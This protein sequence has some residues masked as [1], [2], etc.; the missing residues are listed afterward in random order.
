MMKNCFRPVAYA[1][2]ETLLMRA[3]FG[4]AIYLAFGKL[5]TFSSA[6]VEVGIGHWMDLSVFHQSGWGI[7]GPFGACPKNMLHLLVGI[8]MVAFVWGRF[9]WLTLPVVAFIFV[10][11]ATLNTSQGSTQHHLQ[12]G[13]MVLVV[14]SLWYLGT[15]V[16]GRLRPSRA[17]ALRVVHRTAPFLAIQVLAAAYVVAGISKLKQSGLAWVTDSRF[18]PVALRKTADQHYFSVTDQVPEAVV[19]LSDR[20]P[21]LVRELFLEHPW[22]AGI[23]VGPGLFL[24]LLAFLA[25]AGRSAALV[26][27]LLLMGFHYMVSEVMNLHFELNN[28]LL[29]IFLVNVPF[30]IVVAWRRLA[31]CIGRA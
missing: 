4:L 18:A 31:G 17:L 30:W 27:G 26:V 12:A 2:W 21:L 11:T 29:F 3:F 13:G 23:F 25:L 20:L 14:L 1:G 6:E 15:A 22:A 16:W 7:W 28:Q 10:G 8:G 19:G 5:Q 24:E 9:A